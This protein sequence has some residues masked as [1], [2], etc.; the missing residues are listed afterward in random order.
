MTT[1]EILS[2]LILLSGGWLTFMSVSLSAIFFLSRK[3]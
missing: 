2:L 3:K 1:Y